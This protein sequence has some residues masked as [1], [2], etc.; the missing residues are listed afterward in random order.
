MTKNEKIQLRF[1]FPKAS[2]KIDIQTKTNSDTALDGRLVLNNQLDS[3]LG[4]GKIA[5]NVPDL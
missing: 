1:K 5:T 2:Q 3:S 4:N